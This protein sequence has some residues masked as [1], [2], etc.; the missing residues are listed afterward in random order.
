MAAIARSGDAELAN[1][2]TFLGQASSIKT[3]DDILG[4]P[5]NWAVVTAAF[6]IPQQIAFQDPAGQKL[7]ITDK[8]DISRFQNPKYVTSVTDQYLLAMQQQAQAT[9]ASTDMTSL[10]VRGSGLYV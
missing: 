4:D 8:V 10:A 2:L 5:T 7:S 9:T 3:P 1:A 6:G